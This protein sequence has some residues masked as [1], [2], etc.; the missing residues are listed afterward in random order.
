MVKQPS[1]TMEEIPPGYSPGWLLSHFLHQ[2]QDPRSLNQGG[3]SQLLIIHSTEASRRATLN[4]LAGDADID[5]PVDRTSHHT[6]D[7]LVASLHAEL[8][9]P[10]LLPASG[11]FSI[12]LHAECKKAAQRLEFPLM[13]SLPDHYWGKGK[14]RDLTNL[15]KSLRE[16]DVDTDFSPD[17][18][19]FH[20]IIKGVSNQLNGIH[21]D[22]QMKSLVSILE[23]L[24]SEDIPFGLSSI[25]GILMLDHPPTLSP[26]RQ[27]LVNS[28]VRFRP[29]H[30]LANFGSYRLGVHGFVANDIAAI[31]D[32]ASL[33]KW[34]P[35]HSPFTVEQLNSYQESVKQPIRMLVP[36]IERSIESTH[37]LIDA[38]LGFDSPP[39]SIMIIDPSVDSNYEL[40]S[41]MLDSFG[42]HLP[43][44]S[45]P[46]K[47]SPGVHW[48]SAIVSLSHFEDAWSLPQLRAIAIQ[49]TLQFN[50]DWLIGEQ[51]PT[52]ADLRPIPDVDVLEEVSRGFHL[53]GGQG[54]L[55]RWL[56][57]LARKPIANAYQD[58]ED[59]CRRHEATQWWL[60]SLANRLKPL[61]S[62][63]D[64]SVLEDNMVAIGCYT[65]EQLPLPP[66]ANTGDEWLYQ[67]GEMLQ[68]HL[69]TAKL[70]GQMNQTIGGLQQLFES[71]L[72]LRTSQ[73]LLSQKSPIRGMDWVDEILTLIDSTTL[74]GTKIA[75]S[76]LRL[77]TPTDALGCHADLVIITNL[78]S[79]S[80]NTSPASI[81]GLSEAVRTEIAVLSPDDNLRTARHSW[82]HL[83][84]SG[85]EVIILDADEDESSQPSTPLSEWLASAIW[86][87]MSSPIIPSFISPDEVFRIDG[88]HKSRWG[89]SF[90]KRGNF[91]VARP[92]D[93]VID[94]GSFELIV[95]GSHQRDQRQ[96]AGIDMQQARN[97]MQGALNPAAV[98]IALDSSLM[99]DRL[100]RQ[101][102]I[103]SEETP[104]LPNSLHGEVLSVD[105]LKITP[106]ST[107][108]KGILPRN[109]PA[110]PTIGLK[111]GSSKTM[112]IDPRP[113]VPNAT[114]I[115]DYDRRH[116]FEDGPSSKTNI[117]SPSR[118]TQWLS[119]PRKGWLQNR[120]R[121]ESEDDEDDDV[122]VRTRGLLIHEVW[123]DFICEFL[124]ME[125]GKERENLVPA[126]LATA[127]IDE[128]ILRQ[129][130]L[131]IIDEK[132]PWLRRSD[133]IATVRRLDLV[134]L[135]CE[136][137]EAALDE[138]GEITTAG[139]FGRL[140][141]S[142]LK[143]NAGA[144]LAVEWPLTSKESKGV[145]VSLPETGEDVLKGIKLRGTIDRVELVPV[146]DSCYV[147]KEGLDEEC[148]LDLDLGEEWPA[149]RL[150][151]IRDLKSLE[152]PVRKKAGERHKRELFAGVQLALY[153]RAWEVTHKGDRVIGVGIS[154]VGEESGHYIEA[155]PEYF[156]HLT[157]LNI[158][159]V[160][161]NTA[162]LFR[163]PGEDGESPQSNPF[164]AWMR[165][166]LTAAL[167]IGEMSDNGNVIPTPS[168]ISCTYCSVKQAC[169]LAPTVG[170]DKKW[171]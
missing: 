12:L 131:Q 32:E 50:S 11:P 143:P 129:R 71:H 79:E 165:H 96:R 43:T 74:E 31:R 64:A 33:P 6:L 93:V 88:D 16:E 107:M 81:P 48:L 25:D 155:D 137:Y 57:S 2:S 61:L 169:N 52:L 86:D 151:I 144:L 104:Y 103:G 158:G 77:L 162:P 75:D 87:P 54:A 46:L 118:L 56:H 90:L 7:S 154:E 38:A 136:I 152:G 130:L 142:E 133:A 82:M 1:L 36:R 60:L 76:K 30:I 8:R 17:L 51:H 80:W 45:A 18:Q 97:P 128:H 114:A 116:G 102:R 4:Q 140:L 122:D 121:A 111:V 29:L 20:R 159:K 99:E 101:P 10:R 85:K 70:D 146:L 44:L 157:S 42:F 58:E 145:L 105:D 98:T 89:L 47:E 108:G 26:L 100:S 150:V 166:R 91:P 113:L 23:Q 160:E 24:Q 84:N 168:G 94:N 34:I 120:L 49:G 123:A 62:T 22:E 37:A 163:R 19:S 139:R 125:V 78:D 119:C 63:M 5:G 35:P 59:L 161:C 66:A 148:P 115:K 149:Q 127:N 53:L 117:W 109:Y 126:S 21:P 153:A 164:R 132:A 147:N 14:T 167:Q 40:W 9:Q 124:E 171:T 41:S 65:G 170:G 28:L 112:T 134:G 72:S 106:G 95:T 135:N 141:E 83:L 67:F 110:W 3:P 73:R 39:N 138:G 13:H 92:S 69:L 68:W 15:S 156:A 55:F 27:R